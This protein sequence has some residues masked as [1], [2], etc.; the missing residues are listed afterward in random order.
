MAR[1]YFRSLTVE[2]LQAIKRR[3][4]KNESDV[5]MSDGAAA[6]LKRR[7]VSKKVAEYMIAHDSIDGMIMFC[8]MD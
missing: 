3:P 4:W 5:K 2:A 7:E 1:D 8:Q 6:E